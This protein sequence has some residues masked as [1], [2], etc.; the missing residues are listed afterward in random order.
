MAESYETIL[1]TMFWSYCIL[2]T[3][4]SKETRS[5]QN[6]LS[7]SFSLCLCGSSLPVCLCLTVF[8]LTGLCLSICM[9]IS[10]SLPHS[11]HEMSSEETSS[12]TDPRSSPKHNQ[13]TASTL[14]KHSEAAKRRAYIRAQHARVAPSSHPPLSLP[15]SV[16]CSLQPFF[17][18]PT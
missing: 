4:L 15:Y 2:G 6:S 9:S 11:S 16:H 7:L 5:E 13:Q 3:C 14:A 1:F 8:V 17:H 12:K 18:S 10:L